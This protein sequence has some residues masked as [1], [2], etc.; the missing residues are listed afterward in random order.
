MTDSERSTGLPGLVERYFTQPAI[1]RK[2]PEEGARRAHRAS[3][4]GR[5]VHSGHGY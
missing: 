5:P 4:G 2:I 3:V 1:A